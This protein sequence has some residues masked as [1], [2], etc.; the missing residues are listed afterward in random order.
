MGTKFDQH[1]IPDV[2]SIIFRPETPT[3]RSIIYIVVDVAMFQLIFITI[4]L[5]TSTS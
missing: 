3:A 5:Q 2:L 4:I 1:S